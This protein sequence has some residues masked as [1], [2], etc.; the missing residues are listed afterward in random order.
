VDDQNNLLDIGILSR[1]MSFN[2]T[3]ETY[4][5][6]RQ[7]FTSAKKKYYKEGEPS[8]SFSNFLG[9]KKSKGISKFIWKSLEYDKKLDLLNKKQILKFGETV[10]C[11]T[12][13]ET[14]GYNK[15]LLSSWSYTFLPVEIRNFLYKYHGNKL[16]V[17]ARISNFRPEISAECS[18]CVKKNYSLLQKK[19]FNIFSGDA[20]PSTL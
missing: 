18:F 16:M 3:R 1:K 12:D 9:R 8:E 14:D 2:V 20:N 4:I 11:D 17:N 15:Y 19:L 5:I 13:P 10:S 7:T 6:L